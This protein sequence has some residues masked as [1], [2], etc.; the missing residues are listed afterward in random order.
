MKRRPVCIGAVLLVMILLFGT[1]F[2]VPEAVPRSFQ[3]QEGEVFLLGRLS[4][5]ERTSGG[6]RCYL[7]RSEL[8]SRSEQFLLQHNPIQRFRAVS[9]QKSISDQGFQSKQSFQSKK[10]F[11]TEY[12]LPGRIQVYFQDPMQK[13]PKVGSWVAVSGELELSQLDRNPGQ[14]N[15]R[16]YDR[17][18]NVFL[19]LKK[20]RILQTWEKS[21][22]R[23][24]LSGLR[25]RMRMTLEQVLGPEEGGVTAAIVLGDKSG[26]SGEVKRLYQEGGIAHLLAISSLHIS[27]LGMGIYRILRRG[28]CSFFVAGIFSGS[29]LVIFCIFSGNSVSAVRACIM[30]LL[31]LGSQ[32]TGRKAD[33]LTSASVAAAAVLLFLS[34]EYLWDSS[35]LLSFGCILSLWLLPP[36]AR[37]LLPV[38]GRIGAALQSSAALQLGTLP[39]V[40]YFFYQATPYG[41]LVN[42]LVIPFLE[43]LM[44]SGLLGSLAG[45]VFPALGALLAAPCH[46]LLEWFALVC[47]L[48]GLLPGAVVITGRPSLWQVAGYYGILGGLLWWVK[49]RKLLEKRAKQEKQQERQK[50]RQKERR[51]RLGVIGLFMIS[52]ALLSFRIS[53]RLQIT[54]MDVGQGDGILIQSEGSAF[55]VDGGSSSVRD[56]WQYRMESTLKYYGI[57]RLDAVFLSHGDWDHISGVLQLLEGYQKNL[58]GENGGGI[59]VGQIFLPDGQPGE[60]RELSEAAREDPLERL[61]LLAGKLGIPVK[62]FPAGAALTAGAVR[63]TCLAPERGQLTGD[64]NQDSMV[65]LLEYGEAVT[66]L[67]T[68]DLEGQ[69]ERQLLEKLSREKGEEQKEQKEKKQRVEQAKGAEKLQSMEKQTEKQE[70]RRLDF[71]KVGHHG[72]KNASS[73]EFLGFFRPETAVISVGENNRYGH[74]SPEALQRLEEAGAGIYRTDRDGAVTGRLKE[75]E[76]IWT[77]WLE[78]F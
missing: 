36:L 2:G 43:L 4:S 70:S 12:L 66:G 17:A 25:E 24:F 59:S 50:E 76:M 13:I 20:A 58:L 18:R 27:L 7:T 75:G 55:L 19:I 47:K 45:I 26:L 54:V 72:S 61:R 3:I 77:A 21:G 67:F 10:N 22:F 6:V 68:G 33:G 78:E 31:W 8:L 29:F 42:F 1:Y 48:E 38:P 16:A 9:D 53:P 57:R 15:A 40:L 39:I 60:Y 46:Y 14:F 41:I 73:R 56:V 23:D 44:V 34:P 11:Q 30:F 63:F 51:F 71:L 62:T 64:S 32:I 52:V 37:E 74:P 49:R 35:F 69:G 28:G 65:L 5:R